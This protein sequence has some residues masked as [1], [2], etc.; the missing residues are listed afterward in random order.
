M[1]KPCTSDQ[2]ADDVGGLR[3]RQPRLD[4]LLAARAD[5]AR[6]H[7]AG[8]VHGRAQGRPAHIQALAAEH[9]HE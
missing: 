7:P 9:Q 1:A 8:G 2:R 6:E 5:R 3:Q 4:L